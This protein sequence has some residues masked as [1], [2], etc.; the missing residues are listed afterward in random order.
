MV[1]CSYPGWHFST[2]HTHAKQYGLFKRHLGDVCSY[3]G[4]ISA[5]SEA[6]SGFAEMC[7]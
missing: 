5:I 3:F 1:G 6:L 2:D 7:T 4:H